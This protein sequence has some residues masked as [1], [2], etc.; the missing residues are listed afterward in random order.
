MIKTA[1]GRND[2]I[3]VSPLNPSI[4]YAK[5]S[6][7]AQSKKP[8][9][10]LSA[11]SSN[12]VQLPTFSVLKI[13]GNL[14]DGDHGEEHDSK[15]KRSP[16]GLPGDSLGLD[17]IGAKADPWPKTEKL[18]DLTKASISKFNGWSSIKEGA[19]KTKG[20]KKNDEG[21]SH[22]PKVETNNNRYDI[23]EGKKL[24]H[25]MRLDQNCRKGP[26][27]TGVWILPIRCKDIDEMP[28]VIVVIGHVQRHM[29]EDQAKH[30]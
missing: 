5:A 29:I 21:S 4:K 13:I 14:V 15:G 11:K 12:Q 27:P 30:H 10:C 19:E 7:K 24:T 28:E 26:A 25:L 20:Q 8:D 17:I 9:P 16:E 2:A 1:K 18:R 3:S 6:K 23:E 22:H